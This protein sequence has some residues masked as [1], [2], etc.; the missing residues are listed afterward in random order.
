MKYRSIIEPCL[1]TLNSLSNPIKPRISLKIRSS[2]ISKNFQL[3]RAFVVATLAITIQTRSDVTFSGFVPRHKGINIHVGLK[4]RKEASPFHPI[5]ML[6]IAT[7]RAAGVFLMKLKGRGGKGH[8]FHAQGC[9]STTYP[10][11]VKREKSFQTG[12][13]G[14]S[15]TMSQLRGLHGSKIIR[16]GE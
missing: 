5:C 12:E 9:V 3:Y 2:R 10:R 8:K 15:R 4:P 7:A 16:A 14:L 1:R 6:G 13:E 11:R